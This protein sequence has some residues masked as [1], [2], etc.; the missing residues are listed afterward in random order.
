M[1]LKLLAMQN[2]EFFRSL[3]GRGPRLYEDLEKS[4]AH[5]LGRLETQ[6]KAV[7]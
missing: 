2:P 3:L 1:R 5:E 7:S 6:Q 4:T